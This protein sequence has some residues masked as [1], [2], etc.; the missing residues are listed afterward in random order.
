M[1]SGGLQNSYRDE[2]NDSANENNEANNFTINHIKTTRSKSFWY[3]TKILKAGQ[4]M[5][6]Y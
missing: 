5:I 3:K 2:V 4:E 6:I 1:T